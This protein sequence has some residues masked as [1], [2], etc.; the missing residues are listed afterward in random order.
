MSQT[1]S[2][3]FSTLVT[4]GDGGAYASPTTISATLQAS[5]GVA[6]L[7]ANPWTVTLTGAILSPSHY[8]NLIEADRAISFYNLGT[9][10]GGASGINLY[11][12]GA[13]NNAGA[14]SA[15]T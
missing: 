5:G 4:L 7:V 6:M 15:Y 3:Y 11:A 14:I 2:G 8:G 9:I 10:S 1:I 13:I 12:G